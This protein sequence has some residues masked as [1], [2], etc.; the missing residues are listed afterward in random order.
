MSIKSIIHNKILVP[1]LRVARSYLGPEQ[2]LMSTYLRRL[3]LESSAKFVW[4]NMPTAVFFSTREKLW[5]FCLDQSLQ[6][7]ERA[8]DFYLEFGVFNG[9][10]IR[11]MAQKLTQIQ[12]HG[13][14][15]FLG[16]EEHWGGG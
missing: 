7:V 15:S 6:K 5:D 1:T 3:A 2:M 11:Y 16:L 8:N 12:F 10:S 9:E 14:D 13:F 4:E